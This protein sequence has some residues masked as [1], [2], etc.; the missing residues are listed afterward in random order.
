MYIHELS[1]FFLCFCYGFI[2]LFRCF[3][4]VSPLSLQE[5]LLQLMRQ[6]RQ[7]EETGSQGAIGE[8]CRDLNRSHEEFSF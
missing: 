1:C 5:K 7:E 2:A 3:F 4:D 8:G 6:M